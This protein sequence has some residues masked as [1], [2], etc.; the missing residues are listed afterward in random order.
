MAKA[1]R[2]PR[3]PIEPGYARVRKALVSEPPE[4]LE[5]LNEAVEEA[6]EDYRRKEE[7]E[8]WPWGP[9]VP[10]SKRG[11]DKSHG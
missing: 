10:I 6:I 5:S 9:H 3:N 8:K 1:S 4:P 2:R 7:G 11:K